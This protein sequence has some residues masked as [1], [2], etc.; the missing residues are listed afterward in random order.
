MP[1]LTANIYE[2]KNAGTHYGLLF[3]AWGI[4]GSLAPGYLASIIQ[5]TE[6]AG[7]LTAGHN[8]AYLTPAAATARRGAVL[9]A[10]LRRR[11]RP[12][13]RSSPS[14]YPSAGA[15]R[16]SCGAPGRD[17]WPRA[18]IPRPRL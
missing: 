16:E 10:L 3:T 5:S 7:S 9:A 1:S 8:E 2:L 15:G 13:I 12:A 11:G 14:G 18:G 6:A 17:P 4:C